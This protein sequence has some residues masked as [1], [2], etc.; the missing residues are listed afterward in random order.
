MFLS[1]MWVSLLHLLIFTVWKTVCLQIVSCLCL[2]LGIVKL[3]VIWCSAGSMCY[4]YDDRGKLPATEPREIPLCELVIKPRWRVHLQH[5]HV[6]S[7]APLYMQVSL[8]RYKGC[9]NSNVYYHRHLSLAS[10]RLIQSISPHPTSWRPIYTRSPFVTCVSRRAQSG[11]R[12]SFG[13]RVGYIGSTHSLRYVYV[14]ICIWDETSELVRL[15]K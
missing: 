11:R 9:Q 15:I 14:C 2:R 13:I 3:Y 8:N 5:Q 4:S 7:A 10:A 6:S 12:T 1:S